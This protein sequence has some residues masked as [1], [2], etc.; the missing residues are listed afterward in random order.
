VEPIMH[1]LSLK[2]SLKTR[3]KRMRRMKRMKRKMKRRRTQYCG[4]L[5]S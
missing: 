2:L 3:M 1:I 5:P 4:I